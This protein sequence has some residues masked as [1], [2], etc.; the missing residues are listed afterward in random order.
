MIFSA[1][2]FELYSMGFRFL[3]YE[4]ALSIKNNPFFILFAVEESSFQIYTKN[5]T[6]EQRKQLLCS[7]V[8]YLIAYS[9][10]Q[11]FDC[12]SVLKD[13]IRTIDSRSKH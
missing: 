12:N 6:K 13:T 8:S 4:K 2:L 11:K 5:R 10:V 7:F 9:D 1:L 3:I